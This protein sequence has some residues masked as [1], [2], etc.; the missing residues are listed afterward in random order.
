[1]T[2]QEFFELVGEKPPETYED[3]ITMIQ[4]E[5]VDNTNE[6]PNVLEELNAK[7]L[8]RQEADAAVE[9]LS[10]EEHSILAAW[11][12]SANNIS[13]EGGQGESSCLDG[14]VQAVQLPNTTSSN[15]TLDGPAS[16]KV[17]NFTIND[18]T[19]SLGE[20]IGPICSELFEADYI[21]SAV[22]R[23]APD[24]CDDAAKGDQESFGRRAANAP[25]AGI[26][27]TPVE[28]FRLDLSF[29]YDSAQLTQRPWPYNMQLQ[30]CRT[31]KD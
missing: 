27:T 23:H 31:G 9:K 6:H 20:A 1:M 19:S 21:P 8:W 28:E 2:Y 29:D 12:A 18:F 17:D 4:F 14:D 11:R 7:H 3:F 16:L 30:L 22:L 25:H 5:L 13:V 10:K 26:S 15:F 24:H